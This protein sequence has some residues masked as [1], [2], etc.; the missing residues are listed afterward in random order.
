MVAEQPSGVKIA[1]KSY[2]SVIWFRIDECDWKIATEPHWAL[3]GQSGR[4]KCVLKVCRVQTRPIRTFTDRAWMYIMP[5]VTNRS[6]WQSPVQSLQPSHS[7][8][9][10]LVPPNLSRWKNMHRRDD[11]MNK[12]AFFSKSSIQLFLKLRYV[13]ELPKPLRSTSLDFNTYWQEF[14]YLHFYVA[15]FQISCEV[16]QL[17]G[18]WTRDLKFGN[19]KMQISEFLSVSIKVQWC[20]AKGLW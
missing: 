1:E 6:R 4:P 5:T 20:I 9:L 18:L 2:L 11:T 14:W 19:I 10:P 8:I 16:H 15:K 3:H 17:L 13:L 12:S 7:Q